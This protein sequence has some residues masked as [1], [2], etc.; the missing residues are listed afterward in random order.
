MHSPGNWWTVERVARA[1]AEPFIMQK[2][3]LRRMPVFWEAYALVDPAGTVGGV[4]VYGQPSPPVQKHAFRDRGWRL[5]EL[6][7][8]V[9]QTADENAASMLVGRSLRM[10]SSQPAAVVSYAD[11]AQGHV[12]IIYQ[13]TNWL[14]TGA[15]KGHD[16]TYMVNGERLQAITVRDRFGVADPVRWAREHGVEMIPASVKHRYFQLVGNKTDRKRMR[17]ALRY[18]VL[19]EYPKGDK[20]LYDAGPELDVAL[21]PKQS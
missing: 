14:Y 6:S 15:V 16:N 17:A 4:V 12:G 11:S 19:P 21:M 2:H 5:Y 8:L 18:P 7:R 1:V 9:V 3:Y 13:A 20:T 10:L